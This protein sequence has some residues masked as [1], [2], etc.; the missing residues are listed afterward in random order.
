[1]CVRGLCDICMITLHKP[2]SKVA[3][4]V[5][6]NRWTEGK[7]IIYNIISRLMNAKRNGQS[8]CQLMTQ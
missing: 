8:E 6:F 1:M 4:Q 5:S 2:V 3:N 7:C